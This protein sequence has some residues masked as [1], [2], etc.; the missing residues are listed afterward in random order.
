MKP[1]DFQRQFADLMQQHMPNMG[2]PAGNQ[3]TASNPDEPVEQEKK[4]EEKFEFQH[5]PKDVKA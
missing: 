5:R 4:G 2:N 1:E 3:A